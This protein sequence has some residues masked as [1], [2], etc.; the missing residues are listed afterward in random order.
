MGEPARWQE[1]VEEFVLG[2]IGDPPARVLE[3]GCGEG[4]LARAM[5][6]IGHSVTAIDPRAPEGPIF[7]RVRIEELS[8][9]G[10]FDHVVAV[11][12]L[13]HVGD[14]RKAVDKM[15]GL[16]RAGGALIVVEFAWERLEGATAEWAMGRL[17][18]TSLSGHTSWVERCCRGR[19]RGARMSSPMVSWP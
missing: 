9:P 1:R 17:P 11:L 18:A 16:L 3:V 4:K 6:R 2:Q 10:S 12:S 13:H 19:A 5:A 15:A 8:N 14:L 7:R